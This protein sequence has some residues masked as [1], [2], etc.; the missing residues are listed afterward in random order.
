MR[1]VVKK[2][3]RIVNEFSFDSGPVYIGRYKYNQVFLPDL[4]VSRQHAAIFE[5][6]EGKWIVEDM[7]SANRTFLNG[8]EIH[9]TELKTGDVLRISDFTIEVDLEETPSNV[10]P[11]HL[12]DTLIP[13]SRDASARLSSTKS[14]Y[15]RDIIIRKPE[16]EH[17][18]DIRL[19]AGRIRDF[20]QATEL[21]CRT[22]GIEELLKT[23][24]N[25]I[26]GQLKASQA[27]CALRDQPE[28]PMV[29][30]E[31]KKRNGSTLMLNEIP[32]NQKVTEAI[33]KNEFVLLTKIS[34]EQEKEAIRS[35]MIV[36]VI[37]PSGCFGVLYAANSIKDEHYSLSDLD[38]LMLL[39]IH[40]AAI[41]ENF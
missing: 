8:E 5:T 19:P 33:G 35:A 31:G 30:Q 1:L 20:I 41:V 17:A 25:I 34:T 3:G 28:G 9:K 37:D 32:I 15:P 21:I 11:I 14:E 10:T 39:A 22:N 6:L 27:W 2:S 13:E 7:D 29:Y 38:Y 16:L 40:T 12:E 4:S 36:P 26:L 18:P 23:L 24:L